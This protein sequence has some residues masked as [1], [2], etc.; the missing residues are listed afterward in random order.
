M[1]TKTPAA[2][3]VESGKPMV[4]DDI[5]LPDPGPTQVTVRHFA[6]GVCHSQLHE[7]HR[8]NPTLPLVL[9]HES[10]GVVTSAGR[11]VPNV[12]EGDNVMVT[13][14]PRSATRGMPPPTPAQV[15][16]RGEQV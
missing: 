16:Y 13:W 5:D 14:V 4:I 10:T 6:T 11:D 3:Y 2:I 9:G 15:M 8:P 12:K 7:L 1:A